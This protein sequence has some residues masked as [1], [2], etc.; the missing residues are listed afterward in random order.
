[1][2]LRSI[3][4]GGIKFGAKG[5]GKLKILGDRVAPA[6]TLQLMVSTAE[7]L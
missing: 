6:L 1:L 7:E 3:C 2:P 4:V 5:A